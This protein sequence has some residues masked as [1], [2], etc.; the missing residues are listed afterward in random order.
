MSETRFLRKNQDLAMVSHFATVTKVAN[1][2]KI[3]F[4][5]SLKI[6]GL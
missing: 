4:T 1:R 5:G 2:V 3:D 6:S